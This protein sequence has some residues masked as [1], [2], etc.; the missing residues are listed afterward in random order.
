MARM[1]P[2]LPH[3]RSKRNKAHVS[4]AVTGNFHPERSLGPRF[5]CMAALEIP[6]KPNGRIVRHLLSLMYVAERP[7]RVVPAKITPSGRCISLMGIGPRSADH[8]GVN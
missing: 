8:L 2:A 3:Q 4:W 1:L 5:I 7:I 6:R